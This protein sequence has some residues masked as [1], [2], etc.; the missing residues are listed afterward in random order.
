[1]VGR[2]L[3]GGAVELPPRSRRRR[4][5]GEFGESSRAVMQS[6]KQPQGNAGEH[7]S[8]C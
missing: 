5:F 3:T 7:A 4:C 8:T 2:L 1:M 6:P